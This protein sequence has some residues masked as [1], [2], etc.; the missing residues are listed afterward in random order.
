MSTSRA[1]LVI[2]ATFF[3]YVTVQVH[4]LRPFEAVLEA[5][6]LGMMAL[7][8]GAISLAHRAE[9]GRTLRSAMPALVVLPALLYCALFAEAYDVGV[10]AVKLVFLIGC[11]ALL[12]SGEGQRSLVAAGDAV[13][14]AVI[15]AGALAL[16][17]AIATVVGFSSAGVK[18]SLGLANPN[19][20]M[21]FAF[22]STML[23]FVL[24]RMRRFYASLALLAVLVGLGA[25][26]RTYL[27][28]AALLLLA[29][30]ARRSHL[31][32]TV[33]RPLLLL[34]A[35]L[36][37]LL[38]IG[39]A[40]VAALAPE[41]LRDQLEG[42]LDVFLSYR[43]SVMVDAPPFEADSLTGISFAPLDSM[44]YELVFVLGPILMALIPGAIVRAWLRSLAEPARFRELAA[45]LALV[46]VGLVEGVFFKLTV[47]GVL[48]LRLVM[49]GAPRE[50]RVP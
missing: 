26:S 13:L 38:G 41:M 34:A 3:L 5:V 43:L 17:G 24:G 9:L 37:Y 7:S 18:N 42:P 2:V 21:Y 4:V 1:R 31:L 23:F 22:S 45:M 16:A 40:L 39:V 20:P 50:E 19:T 28:A 25:Y 36:V 49:F 46:S 30:L 12:G 32:R 44:Y 8:L 15:L 27:V 33:A 48:F 29:D 10:L 11:G 6:M 14:L 35:L 47:M